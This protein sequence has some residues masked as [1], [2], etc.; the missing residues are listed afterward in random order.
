MPRRTVTE[1]ATA[2]RDRSRNGGGRA[3]TRTL[4]GTRTRTLADIRTRTRTRTLRTAAAGLTA[5]AALGL[6]TACGGQEALK[7]SDGRPFHPF[8]KDSGGADEPLGP[9]MTGSH[10]SQAVTGGHAS[11]DPAKVTLAAK[12]LPQPPGRILLQVTNTSGT[13]CDLHGFPHLRPDDADAAL[14]PH[15]KRAHRSSLTLTPGGTAYATLTPSATGRA[16][17][18]LSI[19]F[20][21]RDGHTLPG[22]QAR[23]RLPQ[24][25]H[26]DDTAR[27]SHWQRDLNPALAP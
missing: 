23:V 14:A 5:V 19:A 6:L 27:V 15:A 22:P 2:R 12:P 18:S 3:R 11:C 1:A 13:P 4:A 24:G 10:T 21:D 9:D 25:V 26:L 16:T 7:T 17:R 20:T 8:G